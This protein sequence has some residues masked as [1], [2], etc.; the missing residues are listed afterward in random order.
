M[1]DAHSALYMLM[2]V[3]CKCGCEPHEYKCTNPNTAPLGI[4]K[5]RTS[6]GQE[7]IR[8]FG[9]IITPPPILLPRWAAPAVY[10]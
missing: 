5:R 9:K 6:L 7:S 4:R 10:D 3:G 8:R 2:E 1:Y